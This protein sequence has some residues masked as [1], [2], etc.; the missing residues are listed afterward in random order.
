MPPVRPPM[1]ALRQR[2]LE[3]MQLRSYSP[4]T[5]DGYLRSVAQFAKH[6]RT[7]PDRL[8][9]EDIRTYQLFLIQQQVSRSTFIQTVCALRFFY[10]KTLGQ[11]WMVEHIPYPRRQKKLPLVLSQAE[12]AALLVAPRNLKH[13]AILATLYATGLRASELSQLQPPDIES[14]RLVIRVRQGKGQRDRLVML[15]PRL[16]ALLRHYW[17]LYRPQ[18][19]LFPGPNLAH[20]ITPEGIWFICRQAGKL[21]G[22]TKVVH[23]HLLRH[24][25]ATHLL[26]A[27]VDLR[28]IQLLLGHASL[29]STSVY[30]HVS[31]LAVQEIP[32]PL[33]TLDLPTAWEMLS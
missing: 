26:E 5:I 8:G 31:P 1:T 18:D 27:G 28:R 30:L 17:K 19:W 29:R 21:A 12:V 14:Q 9:P 4:N 16:L 25:F 33:E 2:M 20:P 3:D 15:P 24:S 13:R 23:P 22:L 7:S 11:A 6:F 10:E 32:S